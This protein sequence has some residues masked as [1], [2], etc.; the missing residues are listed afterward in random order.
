MSEPT[1]PD[2][3]FGDERL[4]ARF[5]AKCSRPIGPGCWLWHGART[6]DGYPRVWFNGPVLAHRV[7]YIAL[8]SR[9]PAGTQADH[10]C[11]TRLCVNPEHLEPVT[12]REN[13]LRGNG[14]TG[15][16]ARKTHCP[17]G[18]PYSG[19][20]LKVRPNG[21]RVCRACVRRHNARATNG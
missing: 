18:H 2:M 15:K 17:S 14:P 11:R 6:G 10:L 20:N 16:S 19:T 9:F 13:T 8:V 7:A 21:H 12:S 5:W 1:R 3:A 4:P